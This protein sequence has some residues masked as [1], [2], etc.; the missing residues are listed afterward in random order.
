MSD[1]PINTPLDSDAEDS[2][3][4]LDEIAAEEAGGQVV[5]DSDRATTPPHHVDSVEED[6]PPTPPPEAV[7]EQSLSNEKCYHTLQ[8]QIED[9][10]A[11]PGEIS[12]DD[13]VDE[14]ALAES[15]DE[16]AR[17]LDEAESG[18]EEIAES[19]ETSEE[20]SPVD[21]TL[22]EMSEEEQDLATLMQEADALRGEIA[23]RKFPQDRDGVRDIPSVAAAA[24][25]EQDSSEPLAEPVDAEEQ[26]A[27]EQAQAANVAE[28]SEPAVII[29]E[30]V[31]QDDALETAEPEGEE[32][33]LKGKLFDILDE[34]E[35]ATE[36]LEDDAQAADFAGDSDEF[37]D[38]EAKRSFLAGVVEKISG[39]PLVRRV[40][41]AAAPVFAFARRASR[42]VAAQAERFEKLL[43]EKED[44]KMY[45]LT[46]GFVSAGI[47]LMVLVM[48]LLA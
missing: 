43:D 14:V 30:T 6:L 9:A 27:P 37:A 10:K 21:K 33:S 32:D 25:D 44:Y 40:A 34:S 11:V 15:L 38:A 36:G 48:W 23:A 46:F 2:R 12:Q 24:E 26:T 8:E 5:D 3:S 39:W 42:P 13:A 22:A 1:K 29:E 19:K 16:V 20:E 31:V 4:V 41:G 47:A 45:W 28:E 7:P 35:T 18:L 17:L